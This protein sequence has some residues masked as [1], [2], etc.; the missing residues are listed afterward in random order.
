ME[1]TLKTITEVLRM[2]SP[3]PRPQSLAFDGD[4]LWMGSIETCRLYAIDP[5]H[6]TVREEAAA[7]D[8]PWGMTIMGDEI[9]VVVSEGEEDRRVIRRFIPGHGFR[10]EGAIACPDDTG[11]QLS[12]DGDRLYVSQW[13]NKRIISLDAEGRTGTIVESPHQICGQV[14]ANGSFYL[15]GTDEENE[16]DYYLTRI[17]AREGHETVEDLAIVT[18]PGR[19]LAYDSKNNRFWSNHREANEIVA[20]TI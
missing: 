12:Y 10:K 15:L 3:A 5:V 7:P 9:R 11:S 13:Y 4:T 20:F 2:P 17:D 1:Q 16:G 14:I 18:F 19:A 6:W 8:R